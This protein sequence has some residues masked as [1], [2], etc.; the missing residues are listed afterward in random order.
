MLVLSIRLFSNGKYYYEHD[1][2]QYY[3][4]RRDPVGVVKLI[5]IFIC[6]YKDTL[7]LRK[8]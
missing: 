6:L 1:D 8:L 5:R 2:T 3:K 4:G 7:F